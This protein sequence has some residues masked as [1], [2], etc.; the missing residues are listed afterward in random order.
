MTANDVGDGDTGPNNLQ[1]F[2]VLAIVSSSATETI[3]Q[4]NL[5]SA[6]NATFLLEF[7]ANQTGDPTGF[8]KGRRSWI[9]AS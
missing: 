8:G 6:S 4:G 5:A 1:N 2:P 7:F 3:V 9:A